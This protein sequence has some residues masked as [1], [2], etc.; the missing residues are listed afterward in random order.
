MRWSMM[1][2]VF[3]CSVLSV[4]GAF[5]QKAVQAPTASA[6]CTF[7]DGK[8]ISVRYHRAAAMNSEKVPLDK[9]WTPSD[10]PMDLFTQVD[11]TLGDTVIPTAA[12]SIYLLPGKEIWTLIVNKNV[13]AGSPY[14][15]KQDLLRFPMQGGQLSK[16]EKFHVAFAH[17]APKQ[18]NMRIYHGKRASWAEFKEK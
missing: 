14:D 17:V 7:T 15:E 11:L 5:A 1:Y 6:S 12:Y 18:C 3:L 4:N 16:A 10:S 2:T 8:Q 13:T 9:V